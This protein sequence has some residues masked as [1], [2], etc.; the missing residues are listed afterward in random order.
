[1]PIQPK[2]SNIMPKFCQPTLSNVSAVRSWT[3]CRVYQAF[4][5]ALRKIFSWASSGL[6]LKCIFRKCIFRKYIFR[7]CI[8]RKCIFRNFLQIFGGLV[9]RCIK[10]K[11]CKKICVWQHF[12]SSTRFAYFCT[13]AISKFSQKMKNRFEKTVIFVKIRQKKLQMSQ[14]LQNLQNFAK[15][16]K[17]LAW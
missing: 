3:C 11:F 7:N 13:A 6:V 1:M 2:T 14:N 10:T 5:P 15:F 12:S 4:V 16:Q 17:C 8:F 9:L